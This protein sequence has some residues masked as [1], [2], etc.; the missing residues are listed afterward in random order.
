MKK[1]IRRYNAAQMNI[2]MK[3]DFFPDAFRTMVENGL[4]DEFITGYISKV[5]ED[6]QDKL[7]EIA[8]SQQHEVTSSSTSIDLK[9]I[10]IRK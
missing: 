6:L 7:E 8:Q 4:S 3:I 10:E 2:E 9:L 5:V 1:E